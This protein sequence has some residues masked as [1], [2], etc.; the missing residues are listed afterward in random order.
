MI[1]IDH[2]NRDGWDLVTRRPL[3]LLPHSL[4]LCSRDQGRVCQA[5]L[6]VLWG[7]QIPRGGGGDYKLRGRTGQSHPGWDPSGMENWR[8][9]GRFHVIVEIKPLYPLRV[10]S[11]FV[12]SNGFGL[13]ESVYFKN[14]LRTLYTECVCQA[15]PVPC[16]ADVLEL[17]SACLASAPSSSF[18]ICAPSHWTGFH[19]RPF[20]AQSWPFSV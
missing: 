6:V 1:V 13:L 4:S 20:T 16:S 5:S 19:T 12:N 11:S 10:K 17:H 2:E 8:Q 14:R 3:G 15:E 18:I 9:A 7:G